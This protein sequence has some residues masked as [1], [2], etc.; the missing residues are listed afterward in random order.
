MSTKPTKATKQ[1]E[2]KKVVVKPD[3]PKKVTSKKTAKSEAPAEPKVAK[4]PEPKAEDAEADDAETE[5][6]KKVR[7]RRVVTKESV[8]A[9]HE[10]LLSLIEEEIEKRRTG[11][12]KN[13]GV[14]FLRTVNK[15]LK[16]LRADTARVL[17]LKPKSTNPRT[18]T[19]SGFMKPVHITPELA[20]FTGW[21]KSG[22]YSRVNVTKFLCQ[23][24]KTNNLQNSEDKRQLICDDKLKNLLAYN[25]DTAK[26][27]LTYFRLQQYL[28]K[29]FV[30]ADA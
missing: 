4:K 1:T 24:I 28:Q 21:D 7:A 27:P 14:K 17:K 8:E 13:N 10:S 16:V 29:H 5:E 9:D 26:E 3:A 22:L 20:E 19:S 25:P 6:E 30:K 2:T 23:Y 15:R 11:G 12:D 18:S